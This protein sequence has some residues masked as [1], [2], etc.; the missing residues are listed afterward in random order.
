[1]ASG[2]EAHVGGGSRMEEGAALTQCTVSAPCQAST[3]MM[4]G[5]RHRRRLL[6]AAITSAMAESR[7]GSGALPSVMGAGPQIPLPAAPPHPLRMSVSSQGP[8]AGWRREAR[9]HNQL[10]SWLP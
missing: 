4:S 10:P 8:C 3:E 7:A 9:G 2:E 6:N 5:S 1:M